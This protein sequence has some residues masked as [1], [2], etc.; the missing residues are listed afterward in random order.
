MKKLLQRPGNKQRLASMSISLL[1]AN[2]T[3]AL[4]TD[5]FHLA[6]H[7]NVIATGTLLLIAVTNKLVS[8]YSK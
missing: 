7:P 2:F 3:V 5:Q 4:L 1:I 6:I 8:K